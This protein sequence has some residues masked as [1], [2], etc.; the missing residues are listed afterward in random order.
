MASRSPE[1]Q[2]GRSLRD[3]VKQFGGELH[4]DS[5]IVVR[6]VASLQSAGDGDITFL[7]HSRYKSALATTQASA[8]ILPSTLRDATDLPCILCDDAYLYFA[9]VANLFSPPSSISPGIHPTAFIEADSSI[10]P[11]AEIAPHVYIGHG[12]IIGHHAYVGPGCSIGVGVKVGAHTRLHARVTIYDG[13]EIGSNGIVHSGA[14]IGADG[15]G[16]ARDGDNWLKI[17]QTGRVVI[18]D[19]VEIGANT[20]IDR[21]ALDDTV[22]E[23]GVKLDNQIQI[24]HNVRIGAHSA[25]AGCV[26]IAGST[27]VGRHCTIAGGAILVGHITLADNVHISAATLVTKSIEKSGTYTGVFPFDQHDKWA[28]TAVRIRQIE[29]LAD[30]LQALE[31]AV[32]D[33]GKLPTAASRHQPATAGRHPTKRT[34]K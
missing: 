22:I 13:C 15:F 23:D 33:A 27:R 25:L 34:R 4:G 18:G 17:P 26:G 7:S 2:D 3:L 19:N 31:G 16:I 11:S 9:R 1:N 30:R 10:S 5:R 6:R 20:T 21:G 12:A 29:D 24:G 8:V 32:S 28:R 14:V